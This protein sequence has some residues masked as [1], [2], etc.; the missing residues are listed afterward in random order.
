MAHAHILS[1]RQFWEYD[2]RNDNI[3]RRVNSFDPRYFCLILD[4][5]S[6]RSLWAEFDYEWIFKFII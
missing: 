5:S 1:K 2:G 6:K 3:K 4:H